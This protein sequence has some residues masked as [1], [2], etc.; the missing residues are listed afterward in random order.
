MKRIECKIHPKQPI[1]NF[2]KHAQCYL[3]LCPECVVLHTAFHRERQWHGEFDTIE[4]TLSFCDSKLEEFEQNYHDFESALYEKLTNTKKEEEN[5]CEKL[6]KIRSSLIKAINNLCD[7]LKKDID[8][9]YKGFIEGMNQDL[10]L[11]MQEM[12]QKQQEMTTMRKN[13]EIIPAKTVIELYSTGFVIDHYNFQAQVSAFNQHLEEQIVSIEVNPNSLKEIEGILRENLVKFVRKN[14]KFN[15]TSFKQ[16][17]FLSPEPKMPRLRMNFDGFPRSFNGNF[18]EYRS[19]IYHGRNIN[20]NN[21]SP[22]R[23][24]HYE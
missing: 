15:E 21:R 14:L 6:D 18:E 16:R 8:D 19:P 5:F 9:M 7:N 11:M 1:T 2:C 10:E 20:F 24:P 22:P 4:N 23:S 12:K 13:L 3:P 17:S